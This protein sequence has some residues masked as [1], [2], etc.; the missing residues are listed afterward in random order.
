MTAEPSA[1]NEVFAGL[2]DSLVEDL[3]NK[4]GAMSA[5][6]TESFSKITNNASEIRKKL[7]NKIKM[8][9]EIITQHKFPT[10]C[11][12]DG[13]YTSSKLL[14]TDIVGIAG[15]AVEGLTPPSEV[16]HWPAPRHH[17]FVEPLQHNDGNLAVAKAIMFCYEL[18]L[19]KNAP[20]DVVFIDGSLT[21]QLIALNQAFTTIKGNKKDVSQELV[22]ELYA[23]LEK[24]LQA[25]KEILLS[26]KSDQI[27]AA[28]PK[29]TSGREI[30]EQVGHHDV[31]DRALFSFILKPYEFHEPLPRKKPDQPYHL[32]LPLVIS[33]LQPIVDNEILPAI[34]DIQILYYRPHLHFPP[35]RVE[36][37][38][39]VATSNV[40][41]S[42]LLESIKNQC[43]P[44]SL[45][46]P[47]PTWLADIMVKHMGSAVHYCTKATTNQIAKDWK[48]D[49]LGNIF[50]AM[51][52]YR[53]ESRHG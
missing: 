45:M 38:K 46:E 25:Y 49:G 5:K 30:S 17:S 42:I 22:D 13:S 28:V 16:R 15:V 44:P 35:M 43:S 23:N 41:L 19:A 14:S 47:Y 39:S 12:I 33:N 11:G 3:L 29:Y 18:Q 9:S 32:P 52:N 36:I 40:R 10:S 31:E 21:T 51:H 4:T 50:M 7:E 1:T 48:G 8:D 2:P 6:L 34:N 53:M 20:H 27:Y 26:P 24:S 37:S